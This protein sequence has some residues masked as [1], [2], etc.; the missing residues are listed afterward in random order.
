MM[1]STNVH[2]FRSPY[3]GSAKQWATIGGYI[4]PRPTHIPGGNWGTS[5]IFYTKVEKGT[6]TNSPIPTENGTKEQFMVLRR[7]SVFNVDQIVPP[8]VEMVLA[9]SE[10]VQKDLAKKI[11]KKTIKKMTRTLSENIHR[12]VANKLESFQVIKNTTDPFDGS[13]EYVAAEKLLKATGIKFQYGGCKAFY[14]I[15][16]HDYIQLPH[17]SSFDTSSAFYE[18]AFHELIHAFEAE[19]RVGQAP[20]HK[21]HKGEAY[22]FSELV[23][24]I[25]ACFLASEVGLPIQQSML[26]RSE[27]YVQHW[28]G[29]IGNDP[30]YIFEAAT[31]AN[32]VVNYILALQT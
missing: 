21:G 17:R 22:A 29:H 19:T 14:L 31:Q 26:P 32:S 15:P 3:W 4:K 27:S 20:K 6:K 9:A 13:T 7:Y 10:K 18:T 2:G 30:K 16:P 1:M 11:L 24:E 25:G 8:D 23:A 5:I 28:L 12:Q